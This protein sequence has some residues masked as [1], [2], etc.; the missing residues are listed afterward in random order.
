MESGLQRRRQRDV[1]GRHQDA[2]RVEISRF[3]RTT[4]A[5]PELP[6][7]TSS[8]ALVT[9]TRSMPVLWS[10]ANYSHEWNSFPKR[11]GTVDV[12][13]FVHGMPVR[14]SGCSRLRL[15]NILTNELIVD[16]IGPLG[17]FRGG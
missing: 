16:K 4:T 2:I 17:S 12:L 14:M 1:T 15:F 10:V 3:N 6:Q 8:T 5:M 13:A 11:T 7:I 9:K